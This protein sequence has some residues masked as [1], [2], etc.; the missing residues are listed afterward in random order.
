MRVTRGLSPPCL[1][2][3]MMLSGRFAAAIETIEASLDLYEFVVECRDMPHAES[4]FNLPQEVSIVI[5]REFP[6]V[7]LN[8]DDFEFILKI[9]V[10]PQRGP[11]PSFR[12]IEEA[13]TIFDVDCFGDDGRCHDG[14]LLVAYSL[15]N[16]I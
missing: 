15:Q 4:D 13:N 9:D 1:P 10:G 2:S 14:H 16:N 11:Q 8:G 3:A 5:V 7:P 6:K 12:L